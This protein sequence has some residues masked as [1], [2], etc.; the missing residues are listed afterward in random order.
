MKK[1]LTRLII[2]IAFAMVFLPRAQAAGEAYFT[3]SAEAVQYVRDQM[4]EREQN[5]Q[6]T[7]S[8]SVYSQLDLTDMSDVFAHTMDPDEGDT[9]LCACG[10][11]SCS[12]SLQSDGK[13]LLEYVFGYYDNAE[14]EAE[15][16]AAI[17]NMANELELT[18]SSIS[19]LEKMQRIYN[20]V[21]YTVTYDWANVN[22]EEH[23]EKYTAYS[24]AVEG[25]AVCQGISTLVYRLALTAGIECRIITSAELDHAWN[26][27]E[28][29]GLY[30]ACD[31]T[32]DLENGPDNY[33]MRGSSDFYHVNEDDA[34][35][36]AAFAAAH[37]M[38]PVALNLVTQD[39]T[40][41]IL[42]Y[43]RED[44]KHA[45]DD[46]RTLHLMQD[47]RNKLLVFFMYD[48][49]IIPYMLQDIA[50][51]DF[52][53]TDLY[54]CECTAF[55]EE[56][57]Q[58]AVDRILN[59]L[60]I[61]GNAVFLRNDY[62]FS[63]D[64]WVGNY[65][66][67]WV[68]EM[69]TESGIVDFL[70]YSPT[71]FLVN[72]SNQILYAIHGYSQGLTDLILA[73]F[74]DE[75]SVPSGKTDDQGN[76]SW[77]AEHVIAH[78]TA[79]TPGTAARTCTKCGKTETYRINSPETILHGQCGDNAYWT[80][81]SV[82]AELT[83]Y[84]SGSLWGRMHYADPIGWLRNGEFPAVTLSRDYIDASLVKKITICEGIEKIGGSMFLDFTQVEQLV[85]PE[86]ITE[87]GEEGYPVCWN[88]PALT[89]VTFPS[90]LRTIDFGALGDNPAL[91]T[92][93]FNGDAFELVGLPAGTQIRYPNNNP[94]WSQDILDDYQSFGCSLK[95]FAAAA[96][97]DTAGAWKQ[98]SIGWWYQRLDGTYPSSE[99]DKIGGKWYYF[100]AKGYILTGGWQK[101]SGKW[102]YLASGGAMQT[103]W[104][105][106]SDKWYYL[107][108]NGMM[109]TGWQKIS[110]K[111]Y[112]LESGGAMVTGWKQ[113]SGKWYYFAGGGAMV[114][115]WQKIADVWYFFKS[116]GA[117]AAKEWCNGYWLNANGSWTYPY[118]A[119]WRKNAKG[120]WFG[121]ESGWYAKNCT[122]R[123]D[124]K[125]YTFDAT[126]YLQ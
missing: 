91:K 58:I 33:F 32:W 100:N 96:R 69:E 37:P 63:E 78:P 17:L 103:G 21:T 53:D 75:A 48:C 105:K 95:P 40:L 94:T 56:Q 89:S 110:G 125:N 76:H 60:S 12:A 38:S 46:G 44:E 71:V 113:I 14:E 47:G 4:K 7:V 22:T 5:I 30:Y 114:T 111:W 52:G 31:A 43:L 119:T 80:Y 101:I 87:I 86:G 55:S 79:A 27:V 26:I 116:S 23:P 8:A 74:S 20:K 72:G 98:N 112:Y 88:M 36:D 108:A 115:G 9:L 92:V 82:D 16:R 109:Q 68:R 13:Y 65:N 106:I 102:Y 11:R 97:P 124:D 28:Y 3:S 126:G 25:L 77:G 66:Y 73:Y 122:I 54:F 70:V 10:F 64:P 41:P 29:N 120:W 118:K 61:A 84:G 59:E 123:I 117:M 15:A 34:F 83:I 50:V 93:T 57:N 42:G 99:W 18:D 19:P 85:F 6:L 67:D 121:D 1:I 81:N 2:V 49:G 90:T 45:L 104:Q 39:N 24:A 51:E 62:D 35:R 107:A